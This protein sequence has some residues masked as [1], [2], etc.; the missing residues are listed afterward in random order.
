MDSIEQGIFNNE[1]LEIN[2]LPRHEEAELNSFAPKYLLKRNI[3]TTIWLIIIT[4]GIFIAYNFAEIFRI[5]APFIA[6]AFML[7]F[8]WSYYSNY[9]W[10]RK[11]GYAVREHD[12]I[13]K[14]GF[15]FEKTTVVPFNRVQHVSTNRG[16]MDKMLNLSSLN[17]FTAGG[18]GSDVALPGLL[19]ETANSLKEALAARMSGHV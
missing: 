2:A 7:L 1:V 10:F 3:S 6:G 19:P 9:Q 18:S 12:M 11:S 4:A 13:F 16:V 14:R 17:V 8:I 15:L 5:F